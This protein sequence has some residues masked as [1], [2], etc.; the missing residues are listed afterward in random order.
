MKKIIYYQLASNDDNFHF[1][2]EAMN[3][4][5]GFA[6]QNDPNDLLG[7]KAVN[8]VSNGQFTED[9]IRVAS[10]YLKTL[11]ERAKLKWEPISKSPGATGDGIA[12]SIVQAATNALTAEARMWAQF[13]ILLHQ[14]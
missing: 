5:Q 14:V 7:I 8:A 11:A 12:E 10:T 13:H 6:E 3:R 2:E 1:V 9:Q 4:L